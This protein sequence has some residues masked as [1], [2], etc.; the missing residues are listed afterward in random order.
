M[1][2]LLGVGA[3][4][5]GQQA[6]E[7]APPADRAADRV[8]DPSIMAK[9]RAHLHQEHGGGTFSMV[10]VDLFEYQILKGHDSYRWEAEAWYGGDINRFVLKTEGEGTIGESIESAE[11]QGLYS[12]AIGPYFNLQAGLRY[13]FDPKPS[14]VYATIGVEGLAPYMIETTGALF[15]SDKGDAFAR[16]EAYYDQ[17][18][19][20]RIALQPRI[21]MNLAAQD[22]RADR[23]G[24][25]LV[26]LEIGLRLRYEFKR[27][28][29]P[30]IGVSY[31]R[32]VGKSA[33][34][35]RLAGEPVGGTAFVV[36]IHTWF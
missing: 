26:D 21:E 14:R 31:L 3:A 15:L 13:D 32:K 36:G 12:R 11:V 34:Y 18:V 19:T 20:S 10:I 7:P 23:I 17:L 27:E 5:W 4:A 35:A 25:G 16:L 8:F 28:F 9:A 33:D 22:V 2:A 24:V 29:A 1:V 6:S 30:Y